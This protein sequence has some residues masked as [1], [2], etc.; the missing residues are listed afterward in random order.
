MIT[1]A[2]TGG[3]GFIGRLLAEAHLKRGDRVRV[4]TRRL[5]S[6]PFGTTPFAGDLASSVPIAFADG[7]DVV[8]H[9]AAEMADAARMRRVNVQGTQRL[10]DS[11][12]GR[13]GR[14]VQ[15]SS[16]GVYGVPTRGEDITE[17]TKP[18]PT[19][20]Y[21]A[22][23]L[24]A[25]RA[26]EQTCANAGCDWCILRPSNVIGAS[27]RNQSAFAL[28][29]AIMAGRFAFIG[30]RHAVSTYIHAGDVVAALQLLVGAPS[31]TIVN[32]SSD[33]PW[34]TLVQRICDR[35]NCQ[36]PRIRL[37]L[38]LARLLARTM[39]ALPV[40]PLTPSRVESLARVGG[41]P[42]THAR[43]LLGYRPARPMPEG[44]DEVTD[45]VSSCASS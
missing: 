9:L 41:Y 21:E 1:V 16:V 35:A 3:T 13:C 29:R 34:T 12:M 45:A 33:C 4:L 7:A 19:N 32:V 40:F 8:Y 15:L 2:I 22:S 37:P 31:G 20:A 43:N 18:E 11:A 27:M 39:G 44:F 23:K 24:E 6:Q 5:G 25:D 14:W 36:R 30:P 26:A 42:D 28:V 38:P 10:L 17:L